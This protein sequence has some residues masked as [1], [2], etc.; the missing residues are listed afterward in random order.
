M[1]EGYDE[2]SGPGDP[3]GDRT[4]PVLRDWLEAGHGFVVDV[5]HAFGRT[6]TER[7]VSRRLHKVVWALE[8]AERA[9]TVPQKQ[10]LAMVYGC[11]MPPAQCARRLGIP[12]QH[13]HKRLRAAEEKVDRM[14]DA[15]RKPRHS[16]KGRPDSRARAPDG[17][18]WMAEVALSRL[19][20]GA[21]WI[22]GTAKPP[23]DEA[24]AERMRTAYEAAREADR[25]R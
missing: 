12:R 2:A 13:F 22:W 8:F 21:G 24:R 19:G 18:E 16:V 3:R 1:S 6:T 25:L 5:V 10:A 17:A 14:Y 11:V 9:L 7:R 20:T 15:E 23:L 4:E